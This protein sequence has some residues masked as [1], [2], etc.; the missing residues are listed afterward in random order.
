[1]THRLNAGRADRTA[2]LRRAAALLPLSM[3]VACGTVT[4][5]VPDAEGVE[6]VSAI[7]MGCKKPYQLT[8][9]CSAWSGATR[10]VEISEFQFKIAGTEDGSVVLMMGANQVSDAWSGKSSE[11]ANVAYELTKK[12]LVQNGVKI[13]QAEPVVSGSALSGYIITTDGN[14]YQLLSQMTVED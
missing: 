12:H 7:G 13:T 1:M 14:A 11:T 8:Q 10:L 9:D 3:L 6:H 5:I 2:F 4:S